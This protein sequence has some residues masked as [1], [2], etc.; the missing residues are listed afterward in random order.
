MNHELDPRRN[1]NIS[2]NDF[3]RNENEVNPREDKIQNIYDH[4]LILSMTIIKSKYHESL[5]SVM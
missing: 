2:D 3:I 5:S 1:T 4:H